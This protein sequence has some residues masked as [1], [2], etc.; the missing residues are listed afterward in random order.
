MQSP[1]G[2]RHVFVNVFHADFTGLLPIWLANSMAG[3]LPV[4]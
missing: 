2:Q 4:P 3:Y 1:I